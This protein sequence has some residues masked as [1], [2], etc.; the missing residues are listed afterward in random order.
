MEAGQLNFVDLGFPA[1]V[2]VEDQLSRTGPDG[3]I[4]LL[5]LY[6]GMK[7]ALVQEMPPD[8]VLHILD[9]SLR[10]HLALIGIDLLFQSFAL[11]ALYAVQHD[12]IQT[13]PLP[14]F[15]FEEDLIVFDLR[16]IHGHIFQDTLLHEPFDSSRDPLAGDLDLIVHIQTRNRYQGVLV[17]VFHTGN[18]YA[19]DNVFFGIR[20]IYQ[21]RSF[22]RR[23]LATHTDSLST[24]RKGKPYQQ[25]RKEKS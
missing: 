4:D 11:S 18:G 21:L 17:E 13:R 23:G 12:L 6:G 24:H 16:D 1:P 14:Q 7:V 25:K 2:D 22:G 10:D 9:H 20:I 5:R 19:T 15:Q 8:D 3:I